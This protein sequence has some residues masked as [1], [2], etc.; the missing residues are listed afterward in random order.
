LATSVVAQPLTAATFTN[1]MAIGPLLRSMIARKEAAGPWLAVLRAP[2]RRSGTTSA[3][4]AWLP[5]LFTKDDGGYSRHSDRLRG[6]RPSVALIWG[7]AD[8][9]TPI[10]QGETIAALTQARSFIRLPGVG[11]IPH[12]EDPAH[13]LAALDASI[14]DQREAK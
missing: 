1:P 11:H 4:A 12:I 2:M 14:D 10:R 7:S 13:F 3:Y 9:V 8:T 5:A 6:I